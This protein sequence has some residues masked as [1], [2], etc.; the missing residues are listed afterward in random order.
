M[1]NSYGDYFGSQSSKRLERFEYEQEELRL[2]VAAERK[3]QLA[4][5]Y[6]LNYGQQSTVV[7]ASE[8][9]YAEELANISK[10]KSV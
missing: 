6:E 4:K 3:R 9:C 8:R 1:T 2:E 7:Q 10:D 5:S